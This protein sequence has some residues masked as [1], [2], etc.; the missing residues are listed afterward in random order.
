MM[1]L[2]LE[3]SLICLMTPTPYLLMRGVPASRRM[4]SFLGTWE[5]TLLTYSMFGLSRAIW[6]YGGL[7]SLGALKPMNGWRA[8]S[9]SYMILSRGGYDWSARLRASL[10]AL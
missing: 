10:V 3:A 6:R 9:L 7:H 2:S 8:L 4:L 5:M 1:K